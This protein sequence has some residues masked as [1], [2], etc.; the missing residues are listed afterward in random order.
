MR[1][2]LDEIWVDDDARDEA[3]TAE[4]LAKC[5][6]VTVLSGAECAEA[7]R[8]L[9]LSGDPV[10]RGKRILRLVR[11]QGAFVKPCPGTRAYV[12]CGLEIL[13]IGQGC[14][15]D[16]RYCALLGYLNRPTLEVPVNRDDLF[17]ALREHLNAADDSWH[18]ICTGEFTDSLAL[19]PLTGTAERLVE[20][21][22]H[23]GNASLEIKTKTDFVEPLLGLDPRGRVVVSFSVNSAEI[24]RIEERRSARL[25]E[26]FA[27]AAR[28]QDCGYHVGF[29]F[30]PI[31]PHE[32]WETEYAATIDEIYRHVKPSSVAWIS[33][34][35]LR[36]VPELK[37]I[38]TA[39]FGPVRYFHDAFL[40]G[41][42][43]KSRLYA[44]RRIRI[45]RTL[46]ERIRM[47]HADAV[48][49][50]CMESPYVWEKALGT[51]VRSDEDLIT[52]LNERVRSLVSPR[53][54][55]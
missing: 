31:I 11:R 44:D 24:A 27:A 9:A 18:R 33:L 47:H 4:I 35:V 16:C 46:A 50:L 12:C 30:D 21:F 39:R 34:G 6:G 49:Y 7:S 41:L 20:F 40:P 17:C 2:T 15:I 29:H 45:Y 26:R 42:D 19:N 55:G 1:L 5:P 52:R 22:S 53:G 14:P 28:V 25:A 48:I 8:R 37:G 51:T 23:C 43:G 13:D 36:F 3:L 10:G 54:M 38:V 32:G